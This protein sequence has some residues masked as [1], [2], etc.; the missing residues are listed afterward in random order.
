[1][2]KMIATLLLLSAAIVSTP[3]RQPSGPAGNSKVQKSTG[4]NKA[5]NTQEKPTVESPHILCNGCS[6]NAPTDE[7][8]KKEAYNAANDPLYRIYLGATILGV[9]GAIGGL[10]FVWRQNKNIQQ[11]I[12]I[13]KQSSR[14]WTKIGHWKQHLAGSQINVLEISFEITNPTNHPLQL[15]L[16]L[17][18]INGDFRDEKPSTFLVPQ[19]S[20]PCGVTVTLSDKQIGLSQ[21]D[22]AVLNAEVSVLFRDAFDNYWDQTFNCILICLFYTTDL[23]VNDYRT[24]MRRSSAYNP[25]EGY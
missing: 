11:Q 25:E 24:T 5:T 23:I 21:K 18:N 7:A 14:Q 22:G 20:F 15:D 10:Y 16:V 8:S 4:D 3:Q 17:S 2:L 19:A 6:T 12:D 9:C 13:Q 1:M